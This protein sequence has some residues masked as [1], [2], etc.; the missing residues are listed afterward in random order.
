MGGDFDRVLSAAIAAAVWGGLGLLLM[1]GGCQPE[2][3][4]YADGVRDAE[5]LATLSRVLDN[6]HDA[7]SKADF[8][9]Y[10]SLWT[11]SSVFLGTDATERWVGE[12]FKAFARPY[13]EKGKGWTYT[14]RPGTRRF[15]LS[16]DRGTAWF[17]ELL[18]NEKLGTCRG[19]GV[20]ERQMGGWKVMQYNLSMQVPNEI[21]EEVAGRARG[22]EGKK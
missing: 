14:L 15:E 13:F 9:R 10:F 6:F 1:V 17:D 4:M 22:V 8:D 20:L 3:R 7:A 11:E 16:Q 18:T 19:S 5:M 2:R 21:A 12:E